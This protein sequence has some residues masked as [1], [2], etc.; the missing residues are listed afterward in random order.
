[1][2]DLNKNKAS[3]GKV[4]IRNIFKFID[5]FITG[6]PFILLS[7]KNQTLGDELA[8]TVVVK[9]KQLAGE[10]VGKPVT[11]VRKVFAGIFVIFLVSMLYNIFFVTVPK[12]KELNSV[13]LSTITNIKQQIISGDA[14]TLYKSFV[15]QYQ[16]Q[17]TLDDFTKQIK[18]A[19][20]IQLATA[21]NTNSIKFSFWKFS[22]S[23][24][25]LQGSDGVSSLQ[26]LMIK[27]DG[28]WKIGS[29]VIDNPTIK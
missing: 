28:E 15:P 5:I 1:M 4:L 25:I 27:I 20:M 6:I 8:G 29:F 19:K 18:S 2:V 21:V 12:I 23:A 13:G 17:V 3:F 24:A 7:S 14:D 11:V 9:K 26:L 22:N 16:Q 10:L